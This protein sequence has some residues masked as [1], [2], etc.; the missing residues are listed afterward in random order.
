MIGP[1]KPASH[2][3]RLPEDKIDPFYRRMRWQVFLGVFIGYAGFYLVRKNFSLAMPYL[4]E[5]QG[6]SRGELGVALSA[7]S[8]AY[9][10]SKFLMGNVS[11]RSNL[12]ARLRLVRCWRMA[13]R[14][15]YARFYGHCRC[16]L[17]FHHD[18]RHA[19]ISGSAVGRGAS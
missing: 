3:E 1:F 9:G 5:E 17:C 16:H 19:P 4:I 8:I 13:Q 10:L 18:A 11:D 14:V 2:I 7:V 15:L 6:F 12:P